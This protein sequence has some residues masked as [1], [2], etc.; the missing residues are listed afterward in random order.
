MPNNGPPTIIEAIF[1]AYPT[2]MPTVLFGKGINKD[3]TTIDNKDQKNSILK[4]G[5]SNLLNKK[6]YKDIATTDRMAI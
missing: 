4:L 5:I 3:S 6:E 1:M 2:D